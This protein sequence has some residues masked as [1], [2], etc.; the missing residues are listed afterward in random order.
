MRTF[1]NA[2]DDFLQ[3]EA[4]LPVQLLL[5]LYMHIFWRREAT[6]LKA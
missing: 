4:S 3:P 2:Y 1:I 6:G 5:H